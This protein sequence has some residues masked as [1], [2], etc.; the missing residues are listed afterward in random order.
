MDLTERDFELSAEARHERK[1]VESRATL[2]MAPLRTR[3]ESATTRADR[4]AIMHPDRM[5][6]CGRILNHSR[7][8]TVLSRDNRARSLNACFRKRSPCPPQYSGRLAQLREPSCLVRALTEIG[9]SAAYE[10]LQ[11]DHSRSRI[12]CD[13]GHGARSKLSMVPD[14]SGAR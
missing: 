14:G 11:W 4:M 2:Y 3:N 8:F 9:R 5:G 1:M 6:W 10:F 13:V 12:Q 7:W